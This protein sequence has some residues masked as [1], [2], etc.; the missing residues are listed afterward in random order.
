VTNKDKEIV[1]AKVAKDESIGRVGANSD[2]RIATS[3]VNSL[4]DKGENEAKINIADSDA[5][6]RERQSEA[7]KLATAAEKV[8]TAMGQ[9][10][11]Y[12]AEQKAEAARAERKHAIQN[13]IIVVPYRD[14][15]AKSGLY[16]FSGL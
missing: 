6:R 14:L 5:E 10:E 13:A 8:Q 16:A 2:A 9:Q 1:I 7:L 11:Y 12:I 3:L 15:R 4:A